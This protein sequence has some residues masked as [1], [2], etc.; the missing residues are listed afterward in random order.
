MFDAVHDNGT[1]RVC[2]NNVIMYPI[3]LSQNQ[4]KLRIS[5]DTHSELKVNCAIRIFTSHANHNMRS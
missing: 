1:D 4:N 3:H 2:P 5:T